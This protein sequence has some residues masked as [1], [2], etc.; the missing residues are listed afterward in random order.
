MPTRMMWRLFASM[1][2][3][4]IACPVAFAQTGQDT[5]APPQQPGQPPAQ[6]PATP[7]PPAAG[8]PDKP[9]SNDQP[10][11]KQLEGTGGV[12]KPPPVKDK[13]VQ[14]PPTQGLDPGM[15]IPPPPPQPPAKPK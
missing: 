9:L 6:A 1:V 4:A 11:S 15:V 5:P 7:P 8:T 12:L 14:P 2:G 13:A 3:L 10:L